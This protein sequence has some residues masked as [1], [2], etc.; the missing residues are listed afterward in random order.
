MP[1]PR[2]I[3]PLAFLIVVIQAAAFPF[4]A[5]FF[6]AGIVAL[7]DTEGI[8]LHKLDEACLCLV[9]VG[10]GSGVAV[11][12]Q[13]SL[14]TYLQ[15]SL[16]LILRK[17]AFA[18]TIRMDMAFFDAPENQTASILVSLER[19]MILGCSCVMTPPGPSSRSH[20]FTGGRR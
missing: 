6:N 14:F 16:C 10:L 19:H 4:Q 15:E 8:D 2:W 18:S 12:C 11:L 9:L 1:A 7:F 17:A 13:N 5:V 20:H 3:W